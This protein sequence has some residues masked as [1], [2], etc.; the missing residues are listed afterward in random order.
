MKTL[1]DAIE[2]GKVIQRRLTRTEWA[3]IDGADKYGFCSTAD[4]YRVKPEPRE[5]WIVTFG[6]QGLYTFSSE[7]RAQ[8]AV[9]SSVRDCEIIHV[10]EVLP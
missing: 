8:A 7:V 10:R 5:W 1:V 3:D 6:A 4:M 9:R 2:N